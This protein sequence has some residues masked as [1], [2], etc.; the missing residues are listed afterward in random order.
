MLLQ[1]IKHLLNEVTDDLQNEK[2]KD[3]IKE[4]NEVQLKSIKNSLVKNLSS[5]FIKIK[6]N[7]DLINKCLKNKLG[8]FDNN[9]LIQLQKK[10][11]TG[12]GIKFKIRIK[13]FTGQNDIKNPIPPGPNKVRYEKTQIIYFNLIDMD[14]N[15][16]IGGGKGEDTYINEFM[17]PAFFA[18]INRENIDNHKNLF[19]IEIEDKEKDFYY[20][21]IKNIRHVPMKKSELEKSREELKSGKTTTLK[22]A[23]IKS[24]ARKSTNRE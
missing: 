4:I 8:L 2:S 21:D 19:S 17:I 11:L 15:E 18:K 5:E 13:D 7:P 22:Q 1:E 3:G 23:S 14:T 10:M 6:E 9:V 24:S 20:S 16:L 12:A